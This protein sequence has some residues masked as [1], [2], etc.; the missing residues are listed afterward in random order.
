MSLTMF[1]AVSRSISSAFFS[2]TAVWCATARRSSASSSSKARPRA[3]QQR[4]PE[5]LVPGR[6]RRHQQLVLDR[7]RAPTAHEVEQ[8]R[9]T[10]R[11]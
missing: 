7:A 8:L 3:M 10:S 5:L 2:P 4:I 6:Q 1:S 9:R 11:P